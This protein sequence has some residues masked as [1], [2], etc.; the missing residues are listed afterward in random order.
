MS[1]TKRY[2]GSCHC[3]AVKY[4]VDLA[5]DNVVSCNC[6]ICS[7]SGTLLT[8]APTEAFNLLQGDESLREYRFNK[9]V[10]NHNF[11]TTC[12]IKSFAHGVGPKGPMVA[13][14]VRCLEGVDLDELT[15]QK[16]DGRS[17]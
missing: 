10:I 17:R 6:S 12:G 13:I 8:F 7:R 5:L 14:N 4:E 15:I 1:E 3:G 9:H 11:C 2:T 16:F